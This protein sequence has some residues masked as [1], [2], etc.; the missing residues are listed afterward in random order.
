MN[1]IPIDRRTALKIAGMGIVGGF[2]LSSPAAAQRPHDEPTW[3]SDETDHWQLMDAHNPSPSNPKSHRP[4]YVI[5]PSDGDHSP[6]IGPGVHFPFAH[7]HVVDTPGSGKVFTAE[8]HVHVILKDEE[9]GLTSPNFNG[10]DIS[11]PTVSKIQ[12]EET[13]G[14]VDIV[15]TEDL[16]GEPIIFTC[17]VRPHNPTD[18][19]G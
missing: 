1:D 4:L 16:L 14:N 5:T 19:E 8:W 17:P 18:E 9:D 12:S 15:D 10:V 3:G 11:E 2:G 7:D 13:A 6:H